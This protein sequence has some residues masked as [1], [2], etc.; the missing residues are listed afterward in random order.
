[1]QARSWII[2]GALA[3]GL[4]PRL[5]AAEYWRYETDSGS[6]AFTDDAKNIPAK[7]RAS[8]LKIAEESLSTYRRL[9]VVQTTPAVAPRP[10]AY[11]MAPEEVT[12]EPQRPRELAEGLPRQRINRLGIN[13][14]GIQVD[15]DADQ[16]EPITIDK[17]QYMDGN[18]DYFDHDGVMAPMTVIR[19]GGHD[20]AYIDER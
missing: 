15:M 13:V 18:G 12:A 19:Q 1:M 8:A 14:E 11:A 5:A 3:L 16:D 6:T 7:Y 4:V 20:L 9:S 17:R 10:P 2:A